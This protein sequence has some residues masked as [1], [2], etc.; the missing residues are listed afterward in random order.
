[1][2]PNGEMNRK[3]KDRAQQLR[4]YLV[5]FTLGESIA[6]LSFFAW[7]YFDTPQKTGTLVVGVLTITVLASTLFLIPT[8]INYIKTEKAHREHEK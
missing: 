7:W 2:Q 4:A 3:N 5:R 8:L 6:L 1:M